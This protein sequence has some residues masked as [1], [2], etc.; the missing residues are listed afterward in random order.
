MTKKELA[1]FISERDSVSQAEATIWIDRV[2][3]SMRENLETGEKIVLRGFGTFEVVETAPRSGRNL[4][5]GER[6]SIPS[7]NRVKFSSYM[8]EKE[9]E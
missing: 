7:K 8:E 9:V 1:V 3:D 6:V 5:T 4:R 2:M